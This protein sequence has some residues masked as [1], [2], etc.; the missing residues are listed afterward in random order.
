M[1]TMLHHEALPCLAFS[2][3]DPVS[4]KAASNIFEDAST[5]P[6]LLARLKDVERGQ[7]DILVKA[8]PHQLSLP[9]VVRHCSIISYVTLRC[10]STLM[11]APC[12]PLVHKSARVQILQPSRYCQV[13]DLLALAE[14]SGPIWIRP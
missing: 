3:A 10:S 7:G 11:F 1:Y 9:P 12:L 6:G 5:L 2:V 8:W 4:D 13:S 14:G